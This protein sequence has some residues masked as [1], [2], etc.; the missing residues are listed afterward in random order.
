MVPAENRP[1]AG[2]GRLTRSADFKRILATWPIGRT[3]RFAVHHLGA[4]PAASRP[5]KL[6]TDAGC[7]AAPVAIRPGGHW[8]GLVVPKRHARRAVTR[9]LLK[10]QMRLRFLQAASGVDA[11]L[12]VIRLK[13]PFEKASFPSAASDAL[14][15]AAA[16]EIA[17]LLG[18]LRRHDVG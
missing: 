2:V 11:G 7:N 12:W 6:S 13:A 5:A 8:L 17:D 3:A 15:Q 4:D 10:R 1:P 9:S 16:T 14:R 18:R